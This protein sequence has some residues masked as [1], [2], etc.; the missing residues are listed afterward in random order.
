M[1]PH[2]RLAD[3]DI[4]VVVAS[5]DPSVVAAPPAIWG[6]NWLDRL[7]DLAHR[8]GFGLTPGQRVIAVD[9]ASDA[10]RILAT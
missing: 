2:R 5:I 7:P 9:E 3:V 1:W 4:M 6:V 10:R 8:L